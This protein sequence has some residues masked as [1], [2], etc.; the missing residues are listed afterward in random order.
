VVTRPESFNP[1]DDYALVITRGDHPVGDYDLNDAQTILRYD[2]AT[3]GQVLVREGAIL[4]EAGGTVGQ[5][6]AG[7]I[8][9][10]DSA[11]AGGL[12]MG[13]ASQVYT[14]RL[15]TGGAAGE[16][17]YTWSS[18]GRDNPRYANESFPVTAVAPTTAAGLADLAQYG[19]PVGGVGLMVVFA[20]AS[21]NV[22][23]GSSW[24]VQATFGSRPP[25][26][27]GST[28]TVS[29]LLIFVQG[30]MQR[31]KGATL[32]Y[33]AASSGI[34]IVY[35]EW[36]RTLVTHAD[37][38]DLTDPLSDEPQ[39][40][41]E[42]WTMVLKTTD[43][44]QDA[45]APNVLDRR[46]IA[47][48]RWDRATNEVTAVDPIPFRIPLEKTEG[49]LPAARL[50][51]VNQNELLM[52][53]LARRTNNAHGS[54]VC[55]PHGGAARAYMSTNT[56][57]AGKLRITIPPAIAYIEGV[58]FASNSPQDIELDQATDVGSVTDE[59]HTYQT[60]VNV[61]QLNKSL[62]GFPVSNISKV[63]AY[64]AVLAE[65]M[66]RGTGTDDLLPKT[67]V[68]SVEVVKMGGTTYTAP[69]NYT[70]VGNA[71]RWVPAST[72]TPPSSGQSYT[73][74][75]TYNKTMT[76]PADYKLTAGAVDF[77]APGGDLP[78]NGTAFQTDYAYFLWRTDGIMIR[79]TGE[80]AIMRGIP[81][82]TKVL[83]VLPMFALPY[84]LVTVAPGGGQ[85]QI[86]SYNNDALTFEELCNLRDEL[87]RRLV[88][89][90]RL[91]LVGQARSA[92][93]ANLLDAQ[94]DAFS[95]LDIA[96]PAYNVGGVAFD[97]TVDTVAQELTLPYTQQISPLTPSVPGTTVRTGGSF[98]SL[99]FVDELAIDSP[100]WS[101]DYPVN[102]YADFRPEPV[103]FLI[104]PDRDF[105]IDT[106]TLTSTDSRIV[107]NGRHEDWRIVGTFTTNQT[108]VRNIP[109]LYMRQIGI[110]LSGRFL[111]PG[112]HCRI[113]FDQKDV[114]ITA[115]GGTQQID[116][117]TVAASANTAQD[118]GG[119]ITVTATVPAL[120][121]SG[122]ALVELYGDNAT[123]GAVWPGGYVQRATCLYTSTGTLRLIT[124]QSTVTLV[125]NDPVA[126]SVIFPAPRM[127]SK[128]VVPIAGTPPLTPSSPPLLCELRATDR[129]GEASAPIAQILAS[130][131]K[132]PSG[133]AADATAVFVDPVYTPANIFRSVVMRSASNL[134]RVYVSQLGGPDRVSGGFIT[135]QQI[136][137]GI[138]MDSS[139]NRDWTLRQDWDLRC[140]VYVAKMTVWEAYLSYQPVNVTGGAATAIFLTVDQV[141]PDACGI[142]WQYSINAGVTWIDFDPMSL[143]EIKPAVAA[144]IYIR[145]RLWTRDLYATPVIHRS[146][147][148]LL[149][150]SNKGAGKY[151]SER[152]DLS[153]ACTQ[154]KGQL[155]LDL[156]TNSTAQVWI[157]TNNGT[158]WKQATLDSVP[159]GIADD[160]M[161]SYGFTVSA[162]TSSTP[163]AL[164]M[165]IDLATTNPA[166]RPR[167]KRLYGYGLP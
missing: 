80:I 6:Q 62:A 131:S 96:D 93:T 55:E 2:L 85:V 27:A 54:Y 129:S 57:S 10:G 120:V 20:N 99:P 4:M 108:Q 37:D 132:P 76:Q 136:D 18:T 159:R 68:V 36:T 38:P 39:A 103:S 42:R 154:V 161:S 114:V 158:N 138:F 52:G 164:R 35:G 118:R 133:W 107:Q 21:G 48:Y 148:G 70:L 141:V 3:F 84:C 142:T 146:N 17:T 67:P 61:Y 40:W 53:T 87:R 11:A 94:V 102:P 111:V 97:S 74:D 63:T 51:N 58:E 59:P 7:T 109:F 25:V 156:P 69:T 15:L 88:D 112:E 41:R 100:R 95:S 86:T 139:N 50:I 153:V 105:W 147:A 24:V 92:T 90:A 29:D 56:A 98:F 115:T 117:Y 19:C 1:S 116:G 106:I 43:T 160:G 125:Q 167:V 26:I 140:Q 134:Y 121:P 143:T 155:D 166:L 151:V 28:I 46:V 128:V 145:A 113:R 144:V 30:K 101:T 162:L 91:D 157:S 73:V 71:I 82:D 137:S 163:A 66:T 65:P 119:S 135:K 122:V 165:R 130:V 127:I 110:S 149:I 83:P 14:I 33:P 104:T 49:A 31:V 60:G 9:G 8:I 75:Y 72:P 45:L 150:L 22:H 78:K 79:P 81:Q 23:G 34:S 44:S 64:V 12:Y 13:M 126:Q 152:K 5:A 16:A 123:P 77:S 124:T 89:A 47:L 32:T